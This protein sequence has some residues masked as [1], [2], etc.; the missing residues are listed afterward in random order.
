MLREYNLLVIRNGA[1]NIAEFDYSPNPRLTHAQT[2][3]LRFRA[4]SSESD[5][6]TAWISDELVRGIWLPATTQLMVMA[7]RA[8][9]KLASR[10]HEPTEAE[11]WIYLGHYF[12]EHLISHL[13]SPGCHAELEAG[14]PSSPG[15]L[16][17]KMLSEAMAFGDD[18][19]KK[20]ART[21]T[22]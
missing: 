7:R 3:Y 8:F 4:A 20:T 18:T 1:R 2:P 9:S 6:L 12:L 5:F 11:F 17:R 10:R 16:R 14:L 13:N 22:Q 19:V 21:F 15:A